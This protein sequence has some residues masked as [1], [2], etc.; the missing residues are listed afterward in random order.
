MTHPPSKFYGNPLSSLVFHTD[1]PTDQQKGTG[2]NITSSS[3]QIRKCS[4]FSRTNWTFLIYSHY[5]KTFWKRPDAFFSIE[6]KA[7]KIRQGNKKRERVKSIPPTYPE[8]FEK[9]SCWSLQ[10]GIWW[11]RSGRLTLPDESQ[12]KKSENKKR[13]QTSTGSTEGWVK[14][15]WRCQRRGVILLMK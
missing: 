5:N 3:D 12:S 7:Q 10:R 8:R 9:H 2:A 11:T 4:S 6:Q 15:F 13:T 1:E 14:C